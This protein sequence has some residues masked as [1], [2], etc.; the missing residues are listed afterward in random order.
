MIFDDVV[1]YVE[2]S[3]GVNVEYQKAANIM[4]IRVN[5]LDD[6][7]LARYIKEKYD[8]KITT[9]K[10][11]GYKFYNNDWIKIEHVDTEI[12]T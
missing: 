10:I 1:D 4:L 11:E 9:K 12:S 7:S 5:G 6:V 3:F 2:R 8:V